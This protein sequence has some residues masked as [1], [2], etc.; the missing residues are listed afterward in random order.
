MSTL[1]RISGQ[2]LKANLERLGVDLAFE[3]DLLYLDVVNNKIG[4]STSIAPRELTING[5]TVTTDLIVDTGYLQV[6]DTI[7]NG[8]TGDI[9]SVGN[10]TTTVNAHSGN[11]N[12]SELNVNS[13]NF[14]N[15][16][17]QTTDTNTNLELRVNG[18]GRVE[19]GT[20]DSS[21]TDVR[22]RENLHAVGDITLD[23]NITF[24]IAVLKIM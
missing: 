2:M 10:A 21:F 17:I 22:V 9:S 11:V 1:G 4:V 13:L 8:A 12:L 5:T 14:N 20:D 7:I 16:T 23:G 15:S 24:E 3:N 18:T 6:V 19:F